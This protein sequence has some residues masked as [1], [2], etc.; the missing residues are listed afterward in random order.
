MKGSSPMPFIQGRIEA[1]MMSTV[2]RIQ[3]LGGWLRTATD[4]ADGNDNL[5]AHITVT[6]KPGVL[7]P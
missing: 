3:K 7:V 5:I 1:S 2:H 4:V 6:L